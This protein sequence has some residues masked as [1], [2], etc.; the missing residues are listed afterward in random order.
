MGKKRE[1]LGLPWQMTMFG[2]SDI[3][4]NVCNSTENPPEAELVGAAENKCAGARKRNWK[5]IWMFIRM[6]H[7]LQLPVIQFKP[8]QREQ[9]DPLGKHGEKREEE[10]GGDD[11]SS[12]FSYRVD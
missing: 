9:S 4:E 12:A 11:R 6:R 3:P 1:C 10:G 5:R 7:N 8:N 2:H